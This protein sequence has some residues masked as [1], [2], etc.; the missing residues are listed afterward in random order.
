MTSISIPDEVTYIKSS[1][2][3]NCYSLI[4]ID[5]P[6]GVTEIWDSAFN[7]CYS[8]TSISVPDGVT[9]IGNYTFSGCSSLTSISIPDGV[10][11]IWNSAFNSWKNLFDILL[12]SKPILSNTNAF[13]GTPSTQKI[14]VPR[15]NISWFENTTNWVTYCD[16][17]V[18]IEDNIAYLESLGYNVD[19]Y[20]N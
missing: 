8:L 3:A 13:S 9:S 1:A 17:F 12:E 10:A 15:A 4:S 16:R 7:N 11:F 2:F 5:I 18:A 14:Y 6:D 19:K 20:K